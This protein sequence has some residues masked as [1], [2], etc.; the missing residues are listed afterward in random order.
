M[1]ENF[2]PDTL[3]SFVEVGGSIPLEVWGGLSPEARQALKL[4]AWAIRVQTAAL[5]A[6]AVVVRLSELVDE[7]E[8]VEAAMDRLEGALA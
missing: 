5:V 8:P 7:D 6:D 2:G 4:A 1:G 3:A